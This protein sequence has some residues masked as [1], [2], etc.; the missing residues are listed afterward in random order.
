MPFV[1]DLKTGTVEREDRTGEK[2][3]LRWL[4]PRPAGSWPNATPPGLDPYDPARAACTSRPEWLGG[5][6]GRPGWPRR[7]SWPNLR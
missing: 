5:A 6:P 7:C 2:G 4:D 3:P 1:I